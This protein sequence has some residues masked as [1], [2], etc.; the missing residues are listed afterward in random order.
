MS[1]PV[2]ALGGASFDGYVT[3]RE[4]GPQGMITLRGDLGATR[5]KEAVK[6]AVGT[7]VPDTRRIEMVGEKGAGW[8]SP[9]ELL[10]WLPYAEVP[11][12]LAALTAALKGEHALAIDVSDAR[13]VFRIEGAGAREVLAK[14]CPVDLS[15]A[16]FGPGE[17]RRTRAAQVAAAFWMDAEGGFTLVSF[18]SVAAYVMG[19]LTVSAT[20]GGE[21]G[22]F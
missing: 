7:E 19:L 10:L 13:A 12:T 22:L 1:D 2:S 8:M 21:V 5:L 20:P 17:L 6:A 14:L 15:P 11:A 3:V 16:V 18:R 9:D 4:V